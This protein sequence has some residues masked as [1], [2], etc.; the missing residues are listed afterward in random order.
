[1]IRLLVLAAIGIGL[2]SLAWELTRSTTAG[3][4]VYG[5][6]SCDGSVN[7]IDAAVI[8]QYTADLT[9][10]VPCPQNADVDGNLHISS[11]DAALVLQFGAGLLPDL[12]PGVTPTPEGTAQ[13]CPDGF[14]WNPNKGHCDSGECPPGF[15]F[16]EETF[17]CEPAPPELVATAP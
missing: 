5:D 17:Y 6:A 13:L 9:P 4:P 10:S 15:V 8:L 1:M 3:A 11:L 14:F 12:E 16:N 2:S 7:S